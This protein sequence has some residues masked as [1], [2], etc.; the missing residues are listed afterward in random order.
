MKFSKMFIPTTKETPNDAT[1]PSH[2]YL[3]RGGFIAQ[4]GAGIYDFMPLGKI[5]LEKIRAIVKEEMDEAGA[6]EVQFGFVTPL[7][8]WQESGRATT[9]GAEMLRFK[10]RKNGEF[11]LS[12]TNEE[13]VVNMVKNRI[14]SYKDLPLHLYQINTKFRDEARPRFGLMRGRE[15]LM[16]D[17]YSFHSSEEDL[18]REFNLMETTYKKIYTKL[19]LDFRV[20][21]ADSGAIGGS[22]SK[23]FHVIADSGEDTLVVCDSCDYG[24]NIEA[25]IRKP[26]TYS[27]ERK[28][29]SKKIHTPNTKTIEEVA[30]FLNI[31]KEQ[32]IK[33]VI[34]KAIYEEKTQIVIF[35]VRGSDELEETKACN[36]V[37]A[38]ELIDASEDDIKEAGLVAGYCGLFNLPSNI[39]FIIDLELKDEIGLA[40]GANEEDYHLVNTDLSTLKD[41]KYYDLIAVQEGDI[42]ACCGGK[43]SYTKGIE[44]G[45]IFQ[46][47]T[48]YS[49]A[50]NANFLDENGKA[51]PF[52]MGCYG[53]GVSRLVAAVIEQNHD[54]KGCIWTKATA[55]FMVDIIVSNSKKEEEAKVGEELYSKLKQAGISTILDDRINARFG[56]KMSDFELLGFPYAVVIG[57]KLEDG[58]VEIVDRKTLE[59]IDV[60]VD[61]VISKILELVK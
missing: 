58:L 19:G 14:T 39:N 42:C 1:L 34:K 49:S 12:P 33:A 59:K 31:S 52:I 6:N 44:A 3:V 15:F 17:G 56:F 40:C 57:K 30:N 10:D 32:T 27:F 43:L 55:P 41:V 35:F 16:K 61:E 28:S 36:A 48:K 9:M 24:A 20:V 37:N 7:T 21:A 25:A 23:E 29:D 47:G 51:K 4:T 38:L 50:M 13:A 46:L 53:I 18:V 11:V 26:K 45:H 5:V 54:D 8:L 22:G 60:K 2:Q